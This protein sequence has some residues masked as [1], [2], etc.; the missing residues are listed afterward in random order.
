MIRPL[1]I[2]INLQSSICNLHL[3][4]LIHY[5]Q[6]IPS[7]FNELNSFCGSGHDCCFDFVIRYISYQ[8]VF[9]VSWLQWMREKERERERGE[10]LNK[11]QKC[12]KLSLISCTTNTKEQIAALLFLLELPST[13]MSFRTAI[14]SNI[15]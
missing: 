2:S 10:R 3:I 11:F 4:L 7:K 9:N 1:H 8:T 6:L 13:V 5:L 15:T 14:I 12:F